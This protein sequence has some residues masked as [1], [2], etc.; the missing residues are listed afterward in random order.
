MSVA[1]GLS[2]TLLFGCGGPDA[3]P[4]P[5]ASMPMDAGVSPDL[6]GSDAGTFPARYPTDRTLSPITPHVASGLRDALTRGEGARD[7]FIK[8]GASASES[9]SFLHC[10]AGTNVDLDGRGHLDDTLSHFRA[11][12]IVDTTPFNRDSLS[13]LRGRGAAWALAGDPSPLEQEVAA[14]NPSYAVIMYGT[15]DIEQTNVFA[16]ANSLLD[17]T[18]EL[19]DQGI[20]PLWTTIM[21]RDDKPE[22][23]AKVPEFNLA[24]RA[25]A[26]ARQVPLIDFHRELLPLPD[27]GLSSDLLHPSRSPE[28]SCVFTADGLTY[29]YNLR[30]LITLETLDRVREVVEGGAP[31]DVAGV[32][33]VGEGS[34]SAPFVVD[35]FPFSHIGSTLFSPHDLIDTYSGCA[36]TQD[37]SGPEVYYRLDLM[38][39]TTLRV[40]L[41]DR[42]A[43]DI[44][45]HILDGAG[46][47]SCLARDHQDLT[48]SLPAGSHTLVLDTFVDEGAERAGE[49]IVAILAITDPA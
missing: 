44:D 49:Y 9:L 45:A 38:E 18:D 39:P 28:G 19:L 7:V 14:A 33:L 31:P 46:G 6:G 17:I 15:N 10:F 2:V 40:L 32:P 8:V 34:P 12:R 30:N 25:V 20:I 5:D 26:Q 3:M 48:I 4:N 22:S 27:H 16:Y 21:P 11:G 36:A 47:E 29:G 13:T 24:I 41:F 42:G 43:V 37:E 35:E 1:L 23:D